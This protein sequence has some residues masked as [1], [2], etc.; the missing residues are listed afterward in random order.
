MKGRK[1]QSYFVGRGGQ[2]WKQRGLCP[3][4]VHVNLKEC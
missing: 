1:E 2:G 4:D 3:V